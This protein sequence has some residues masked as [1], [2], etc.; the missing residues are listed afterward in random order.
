[1]PCSWD[2]RSSSASTPP[3]SSPMGAASPRPVDGPSLR[4]ALSSLLEQR[5]PAHLGQLLATACQLSMRPDGTAGLQG[6]L[7]L[8]GSP[9]ALSP[10]F[11]KRV[12]EASPLAQQLSAPQQPGS[13][14]TNGLLSMDQARSLLPLA[15]DDP[16][17]SAMSGSLLACICLLI[18]HAAR[19]VARQAVR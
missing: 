16:N 10:L 14:P 9:L 11:S 1:M 5:G 8:P 4:A 17:V 12:C 3:A 13:A 7:L 19:V 15:A 18:E 2:E 6:R